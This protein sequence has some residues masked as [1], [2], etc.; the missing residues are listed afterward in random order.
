MFGQPHVAKPELLGEAHLRELLV[1][2]SGILFRRRRQREG[3]PTETH[4]RLRRVAGASA[5]PGAT[6]SGLPAGR[7]QRANLLPRGGANGGG[8][9]RF[10]RRRK[11]NGSIGRRPPSRL[12]LASRDHGFS[13]VVA[14]AL[15]RVS[16]D[17]PFT[18]VGS[19]TPQRATGSESEKGHNRAARRAVGPKTDVR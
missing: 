18:S 10:Q 11:G 8:R 9:A 17:G 6:I 7:K 12:R 15:G 16:V 19:P 14:L 1:D 5:N 4:L 13:R 2:T 3:E